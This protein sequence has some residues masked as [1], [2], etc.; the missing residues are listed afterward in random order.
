MQRPAA[1]ILV[2][3]RQDH[4]LYQQ[5][6]QQHQQRP[7]DHH[8]HRCLP[9]L[10]CQMPLLPTS[11]PTVEKAPSF[12]TAHYEDRLMQPYDPSAR[13]F[14]GCHAQSLPR[15]KLATLMA[16]RPWK[17][18]PGLDSSNC[19]WRPAP[20]PIHF[21]PKIETAEQST[22]A[23]ISAR[24]N[25]GKRTHAV[26]NLI[27]RFFICILFPRSAWN[28]IATSW[29]GRHSQDSIIGTNPCGQS[30]LLVRGIVAL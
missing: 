13:M 10:E 20:R 17:E 19:K 23:A 1:Y 24:G 12:G 11:P 14:P 4:T 2:V 22:K 9:C 8:L 26:R 7:W 3:Q 29:P 30:D 21:P 25:G 27:D 6:Q 18:A 15:A 5:Q 28:S 16:L